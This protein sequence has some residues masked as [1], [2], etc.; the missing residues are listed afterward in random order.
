M[1][2]RW[3][4]KIN[5]EFREVGSRYVNCIVPGDDHVQSW[6]DIIFNG[7]SRGLAAVDLYI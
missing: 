7:L 5:M 1:K 2:R 4:N 3:K 6:F